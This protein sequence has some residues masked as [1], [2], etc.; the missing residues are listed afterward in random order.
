M[1][2]VY[3]FLSPQPVQILHH[4]LP[5][6]FSRTSV[7]TDCSA[8]RHR[9]TKASQQ[10]RASRK[11]DIYFVLYTRRCIWYHCAHSSSSSLGARPRRVKLAR[12]GLVLPQQLRDPPPGIVRG[13]LTEVG[14]AQR[15]LLRV[16]QLQQTVKHQSR[17]KL[18]TYTS[19][20]LTMG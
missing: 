8:T 15:R 1:F 18:N 14:G 16:L 7:T 17:V 3:S 11:V 4:K 12:Q 10:S 5:N 19:C 13:V 9:P 20:W 2:N 6:Q